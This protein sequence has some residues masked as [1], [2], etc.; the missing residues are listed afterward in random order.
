MMRP[1][2]LRD[3]ANRARVHA[4]TASRALN[5]ATRSLVNAETVERVLRAARDLGYRP[6]SL[7]RGL[8]TNRTN[9][10]GMLLPDL[11]NP[12]FPPI[13][14]GIEDTL[15]AADYTL[16]LANTDNHPQREHQTAAKMLERRVDGLMLATAHRRAP[17]IDEIIASGMP[18]VL[19]NRTVD[20]PQVPAVTGDDHAGIGLAVRHLVGLGHTRIAHVGGPQH[21][22]TGLNRHQSFLAWSRIEGLEPDRDLVVFADWYQE[23]PGAKAFRSLL[24]RRDDFTGVIAAN[25]LIA[26]GCYDVLKDAGRTIGRDMSVVGYNDMPFADQLHPP[27]TTIRIPHYQIGVKAAG[28]M[29]DILEDPVGTSPVSIRLAPT[30]V[31]RKSTGPAPD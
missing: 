20:D 24:D 19:V 16:I 2:T 7:A 17:L 23:E 29:L 14:R 13:V 12:L 10:I 9:T 5:P 21:L 31:V 1:A 8:K 26:I 28:L 27:L 30:L 11:T 25:D 18:V 22:S 15:G 4:S 6:N 3:V